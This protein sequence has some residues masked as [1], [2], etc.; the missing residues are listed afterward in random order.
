MREC[1]ADAERKA[2]EQHNGRAGRRG[3]ESVVVFV[4]AGDGKG[5]WQRARRHRQVLYDL[6]SFS[7]IM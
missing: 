4:D 5:A 6:R 1:Q 7:C 2:D 3:N